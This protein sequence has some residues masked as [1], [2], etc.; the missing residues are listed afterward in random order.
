M[1]KLVCLRSLGI[2]TTIGGRNMPHYIWVCGNSVQYIHT[3]GWQVQAGSFRSVVLFCVFLNFGEVY[4]SVTK[5]RS[6]Y[7]PCLQVCTHFHKL[8][9]SLSLLPCFIRNACLTL[10]ERRAYTSMRDGLLE[11]MKLFIKEAWKLILRGWVSVRLK[12][13]WDRDHDCLT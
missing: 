11:R 5:T 8:L 2:S 4:S 3:G 7:W 10:S 6:W 9:Q 13:T 12:Y 1:Q